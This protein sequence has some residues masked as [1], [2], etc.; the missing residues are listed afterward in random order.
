MTTAQGAEEPSLY[1]E[2]FQQQQPGK[3]VVPL[4][5]QVLVQVLCSNIHSDLATQLQAIAS[6]GRINQD[7]FYR[8]ICSKLD[9]MS[10]KI[11]KALDCL[12]LKLEICQFEIGTLSLK[13]KMYQ[14]AML[15]YLNSVD[16]EDDKCN[17]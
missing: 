3:S 8:S 9:D 2:T 6:Q 4:E 5:A 12:L 13:Q 10:M 1:F 17:S 11:L 15:A 7:H 16:L 14:K